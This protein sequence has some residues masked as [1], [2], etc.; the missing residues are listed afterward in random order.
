MKKEYKI[1]KEN[2]MRNFLA[3]IVFLENSII[4]ILVLTGIIGCS[5][6]QPPPE[7]KIVYRTPSKV[8]NG[9]RDIASELE[10]ESNNMES[11]DLIIR[12]KTKTREL[13]NK[14][15]STPDVIAK[16]PKKII[17]RLRDIATKFG[18][19]E[20]EKQNDAS[21]LTDYIINQTRQKY[22]DKMLTAEQWKDLEALCSGDTLQVIP[23]IVEKYEVYIKENQ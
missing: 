16:T 1:K 9:L 4:A 8:E 5:F 14:A 12:I 10:I 2:K 13:S 17:F 21:V 6:L 22:S 11:E 15:S 3:W 7:S 19:K 20:A 18:M 23:E